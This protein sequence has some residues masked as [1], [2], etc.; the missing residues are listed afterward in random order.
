[1]THPEY[2]GDDEGSFL[3]LG[4]SEEE[5]LA[6]KEDEEVVEEER[7]EEL[8]ELSGGVSED[9]EEKEEEL[10]S[11]VFVVKTT[12]GHEKTVADVLSVKA[13]RIR[14][15]ESKRLEKLQTKLDGAD[16]PDDRDRIERTM[17]S[18]VEPVVLSVLCPAKI[19]GYF[20]VE[21]RMHLGEALSD[22][23]KGVTHSKG[24]IREGRRVERNAIPVYNTATLEEISAFL[25]PMPVVSGIAEGDIVE[26][27]AG[28]FKGE[29][30]R[31][32]LID[33]QKEEITVE[34]L[35]AVVPIPVTVRGDHV[36]VLDKDKE[37][38]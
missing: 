23:L 37:R 24:L 27:V 22:L 3:D 28:P 8:G 9:E 16:S 18:V 34:L 1:M 14:E 35:E 29:K 19:R 11:A 32:Q 31:V 7:Q 17:R 4:D 30:A 21:S 15:A 5:S 12:I 10:D 20:F 6:P 36:R 13:R 26:L 2:M 38:R 25:T 33:D